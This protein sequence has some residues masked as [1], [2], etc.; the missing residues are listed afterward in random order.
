MI[1]GMKRAIA[2]A[3]GL[4]LCFALTACENFDPATMGDW[5]PSG[6]KPLPGERKL[7]FPDGVPGVP[8]GVPPELVKGHQ[9]PPDAQAI[10]SPDQPE[11]AEQ[12]A[13]PP[14]EKPK[15]KAKKVTTAK[16]R[17]QNAP[18]QTQGA[19]PS[20]W[21]A[22]PPGQSAQP[23]QSPSPWPATPAPGTFSR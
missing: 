14:P 21:P 23:A 12:P 1:P 2:A 17:P 18:S 5:I 10:A 11:T 4:G 15:P 19:Q 16:P 9:P 20:S 3:F 13:A 22:P 8:Q 6:K 7:V